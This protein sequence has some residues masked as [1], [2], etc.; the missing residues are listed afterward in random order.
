MKSFLPG[1]RLCE[2]VDHEVGFI[3]TLC[4]TAA[5][6]CPGESHPGPMRKDGSY[7]GRAAPEI[8]MF[9]A[10]VDPTGGKVRCSIRGSELGTTLAN[11][12]LRFHYR[13][14]GPLTTFVHINTTFLSALTLD[15]RP[16]TNGRRRPKTSRYTI[17]RVHL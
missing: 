12:Y 9:E 6:T 4:C 15:S 16:P 2:L 17:L 5:C 3:L 13:R 8:D 1:Q 10:V 11:I 14:N 7:V